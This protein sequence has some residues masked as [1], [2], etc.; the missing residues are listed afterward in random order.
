MASKDSRR[1][2][3]VGKSIFQDHMSE[4]KEEVPN[5]AV[6]PNP[7][8][9]ASRRNPGRSCKG[10]P[11]SKYSPP[12]RKACASPKPKSAT[13]P[14]PSSTAAA[15]VSAREQRAAARAKRATG[16]STT[17]PRKRQPAKPPTPK[18]L[19]LDATP[20]DE[21][22]PAA[23]VLVRQADDIPDEKKPAAKVLVRQV[24]DIPDKEKPAAKVLVR[25]PDD[26]P[27]EKK[28]AAKV[29]VRQV[30]DIPDEEKKPAAVVQ[31]PPVAVGNLI[32]Q[33]A[34]PRTRPLSFEDLINQN[35]GNANAPRRSFSVKKVKKSKPPVPSKTPV[36]N[37]ASAPTVNADQARV[38]QNV[39]PPPEVAQAPLAEVVAEKAELPIRENDAPPPQVPAVAEVAE[40]PIG[41]DAAPPPQVPAVAEVAELPIREDDAPPPQVP[42]VAEV[43]EL[44]TGEDAAPPPQVPAVAEVAEMPIG[45]DADL[46]P[47]VPVPP[48][49]RDTARAE[50]LQ[51]LG[52]M[53]ENIYTRRSFL[54]DFKSLE[55]LAEV[56]FKV[57]PDP[58][59]VS[60]WSD[61]GPLTGRLSRVMQS[62]YVRAFSL[63]LLRC[64][65]GYGRFRQ[66]YS[67]PKV[68]TSQYKV[69]EV[70]IALRQASTQN[71]PQF[72]LLANNAA[73]LELCIAYF[74]DHCIPSHVEMTAEDVKTHPVGNTNKTLMEKRAKDYGKPL[75]SFE[76]FYEIGL[77]NISTK[78]K[79]HTVGNVYNLAV[80][81][82]LFVEKHSTKCLNRVPLP[83]TYVTDKQKAVGF[84]CND[85]KRLFE[86]ERLR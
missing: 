47:D 52:E 22:K 54:E 24:D 9:K 34:K 81:Y 6:A 62:F 77:Q 26:I 21:K 25:Q 10:Q 74:C 51:R 16:G 2:K 63:L 41:E 60:K 57:Q 49:E 37:V 76:H 50:L 79:N 30:D 68:M 73:F 38:P 48:N 72:N 39:A 17:P 58:I 40:L 19:V 5:D 15:Q 55:E 69:Y 3:L 35:G 29:L 36:P 82:D 66:V 12:V 4:E 45:E 18:Q 70:V 1:F 84:K 78:H 32:P 43:A 23:K 59:L 13:T 80:V 67:L 27:D 56:I 31:P 20:D 46:P 83:Q 71:R 75:V 7:C 11:M 61:K 64:C 53:G 14:N 85:G 42:A 44:P 28:P 33:V 65:I 8:S 86:L